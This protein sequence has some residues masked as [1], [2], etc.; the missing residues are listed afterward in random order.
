MTPPIC[1]TFCREAISG[2]HVSRYD[3]PFCWTNCQQ[4]WER[5]AIAKAAEVERARRRAEVAA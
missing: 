2:A 5:E 3:L 4:Q 1:C